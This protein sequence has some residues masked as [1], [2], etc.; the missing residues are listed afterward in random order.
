MPMPTP[1]ENETQDDFIARFM[2]DAM[3]VED[4]PDEQQ[5]RAIAQQQWEDRIASQATD[6]AARAGGMPVR[7]FRIIRYGP[8][9]T[10]QPVL[11]P[12]FEH[13]TPEMGAVAVAALAATGR[14]MPI[15]YE[16][17]S[18]AALNTRPDGLAPAAGWV[19]RL[20]HRDDGLWA[21]DVEWTPFASSLIASGEYAYFSPV[22]Q[23]TDRTAKKLRSIKTITL[24]NDPAL[25][26]L[27]VSPLTTA[28]RAAEEKAR[29]TVLQAQPLRVPESPGN[30][31]GPTMGNTIAERLGLSPGATEDEIGAAVAALQSAKDQ[32]TREALLALGKQI[33]IEAANV[34]ELIGALKARLGIAASTAAAAA[35]VDPERDAHGN[36]DVEATASLVTRVGELERS[37]LDAEFETICSSG[38]GRGKITPVMKEPMRK[39]FHADR[40]RFDELL[41]TLPVL[42]GDRS[43]FRET[44]GQEFGATETALKREWNLNRPNE[45]GVP[46]QDEFGGDYEAFTAYKKHD[47]AGLITICRGK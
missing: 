32:H 31:G 21:C 41:G 36:V 24:T 19:G 20:E 43:A 18:L 9:D 25:N 35:G 7:E 30:T 27:G 40:G 15:D 12:R 17:Q 16:H 8:A 22:F 29:C 3:M 44:A 33:G 34:D 11:G 28:A 47:A 46:L 37:K 13:F 42:A 10:R 5:R 45:R 4:Y 14:R 1:T 26:G 38:A 39:I 2:A 6:S 23:W